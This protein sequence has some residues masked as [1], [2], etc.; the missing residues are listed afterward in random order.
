MK[1]LNTQLPDVKLL[2]P[3]VFGDARGYFFE[4]F[5]DAWF[6]Q[7]IAAVDLVQSNQSLSC[8]GTLRGLHYQ[9]LQPQGKLIR[10][11]SGEIFDVC[12]DLRRG[13]PTLG[14]WTGQYLSAE[15]RRQMWIP[16]GFA[17]GFYVVSDMAECLY[18]C[19][20]YYAPSDEHA[21]KWDDDTLG[22]EWPI[23]P[24]QGLI[25]S[26][27]DEQAGSFTQ[28]ALFEQD[29]TLMDLCGARDGN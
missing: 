17:H 26:D 8:K 9:L 4:T 27:K 29:L 25:I 12:V 6:K 11:I 18:Q 20:N 19:S 14:Q 13:S 2:E 7:H 28:A 23:P 21:I 3:Q 16:A 24:E 22:I 1:I 5:R 15:N 10:V